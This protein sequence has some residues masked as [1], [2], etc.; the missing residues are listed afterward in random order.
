[1]TNRQTDQP[2]DRVTL[3]ITILLFSSGLKTRIAPTDREILWHTLYNSET[4]VEVL[5]MIRIV[6]LLVK[7]FLWTL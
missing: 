4:V 1:M 7:P 2:T 6:S 3:P 5:M